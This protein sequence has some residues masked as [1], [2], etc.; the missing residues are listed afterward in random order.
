MD[1]SK[2]F[3]E[4]NIQESA[5]KHTQIDARQTHI[6]TLQYTLKPHTHTE[7]AHTHSRNKTETTNLASVV[8]ESRR[9]RDESRSRASFLTSGL[10]GDDNTC[11]SDDKVAADDADADDADDADEEAAADACVCFRCAAEARV[12]AAAAAE[13]DTEVDLAATARATA[14]TCNDMAAHR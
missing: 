5:P 12:E 3:E 13:A 10:P 14:P 8:R 7:T 4:T 9:S 2:L 11:A 6:H 1:G